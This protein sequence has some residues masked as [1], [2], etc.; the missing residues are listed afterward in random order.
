MRSQARAVSA[1]S[2]SVGLCHP[3]DTQQTPSV[4]ITL[5]ASQ[6]VFSAFTT[7]LCGEVPMRLPPIS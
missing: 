2:V 1:I 4:T 5:G 7:D 6:H 3:D